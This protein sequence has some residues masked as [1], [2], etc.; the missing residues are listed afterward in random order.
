A[1][2]SVKAVPASKD[3]TLNASYL[4]PMQTHVS[5]VG[6]MSDFVAQQ[7]PTQAPRHQLPRR[8]R[9]VVDRAMQ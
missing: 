9:R 4:F 8:L 3:F 6:L 5:P 1:E 2:K 7:L